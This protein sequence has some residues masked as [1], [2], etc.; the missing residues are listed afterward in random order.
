MRLVAGILALFLPALAGELIL[1][2]RVID[3]NGAGVGGAQVVLS[4][5]GEPAASGRQFQTVSEPTGVFRLVL[6]GPGDYL[7]AAGHAGYFALRNRLVQISEHPTELHL[8]LNHTREVFQSVNVSATPSKMDLEQTSSGQTLTGAEIINIPYPATR[9]LKNG[10]KLMPGVVQDAA[11]GVHFNGSAENQVLYTLDGFNISDPLTG[12]L[13][14]HVSV[15]SVSAL[16]YTSGRFSPEYG[17]GS[18]GTLGIRTQ[19]GTDEFRYNAT[20]FVPG[21]DTRHGP[22]IGTWDP[23]LTLSGPIVR[24]RAW[25]SNSLDAEYSVLVVDGLPKGQPDR[26]TSMRASDLLHNQVNITPANILYADILIN[27]WNAPGTGLSALDPYPTTINRRQRSWFYSVKD[28]IYLAR[29]TLLEL[30]VGEYRTFNRQIPQGQDYYQ[31]TPFG[32]RGN[33]YVDGVQTSRRDQLLANLFLPS[34]HLAGGHQLKLGMDLDRLAYSQDFRRTGYELFGLSGELLQRTTFA[35]SGVLGRPSAEVSS[36]VVD[37][38]RVR[39]NL[40]LEAGARQDWDEL[41]RHTLISP[42]VSFSYSP[43]A[44]KNTRFSGGYAVVYDATSVQLFTRPMDQ[45]AVTTE[46]GPG[47]AAVGGPAITVF[48]IQNHHLDAPRYQNW[49]FEVDQRLPRRIQ[50]GV[51]LLRKR[52]SHGFTYAN[53]L[54]PGVPPP[55]EVADLYPGA[56]FGAIYTLANFRR[57]VYDS[58]EISARQSFGDRYEWMA[59]YTRSRALSNAVVDMSVDQPL[60]IADN[61]G[62]MSWDTPNRF[63]SW[64]Y[65]PTPRKNWAIAYLLE[66]RDGF[67]FSVQQPDGQVVGAVNSHRLPFW[68]NLNLH[69]ERRFRW[70]GYRFAIRG[71]FNNIT[72]HNNATLANNIIGSPQY[73]TYFGSEGRHLVFLLRWLGKD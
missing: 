38:W 2:G 45:Y 64:A 63:L 24:G 17:K 5:P 8:V 69:L 48:T 20:N 46:F 53:M 37:T 25:F 7:A 71:G 30:G 9:S 68:F 18:A 65:L 67:P 36:Y 31:I 16:D 13:A 41:I 66:A 14:A 52:G 49:S 6:P 11:G 10:M 1:T 51:N 61:V 3:E 42:R 73:L 28:Q 50:L 22:H 27:Y 43:A 26:T 54:L 47:G 44:L 40:V 58:A 59:S 29:N 15:D 32:H 21:V 34:F 19:L 62:R 12:T 57:D 60:L 33:Y 39:P 72:D 23:R 4:P 56:A 55:P 35:G 70:R